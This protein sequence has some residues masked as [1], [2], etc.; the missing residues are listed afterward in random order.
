MVTSNNRG[1]GRREG[2]PDAHTRYLPSLFDSRSFPPFVSLPHSLS[3]E[4]FIY[5]IP[6]V[7][8]TVC[9]DRNSIIKCPGY[10]IVD[11]P[12]IH[13][14]PFPYAW[15][16][17]PRWLCTPRALKWSIEHDDSSR[18]DKKLVL[19]RRIF[20]PGRTCEMGVDANRLFVKFSSN[21]S[22]WIWQCTICIWTR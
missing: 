14:T 13:N 5:I 11:T 18:R 10:L 7:D 15:P 1:E 9:F 22:L 8:F 6:S 17:I 19:S 4:Q 2:P 3:M 16:V 12:N 21:F 20:S